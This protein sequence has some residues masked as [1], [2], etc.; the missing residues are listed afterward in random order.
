M[1]SPER[2]P[3]SGVARRGERA[4]RRYGYRSAQRPHL[5]CLRY[6]ICAGILLPRHDLTKIGCAA[7][8][9]TSIGSPAGSVALADQQTAVYPGP[10]PGGWR[11]I[12]SCPLTLFNLKAAPALLT[13]GDSVRFE[14]VSESEFRAL[15]GSYDRI[16]HQSR[17]RRVNS[18]GQWPHWHAAIG[19]ASSGAM[20][21]PAL[22][23]GQH[24]LGHTQDE[25]AI[26]MAYANTEVTPDSS[27]LIAVTGAPVSLWVDGAP[28]ASQKCS[29]SVL[30]NA[31]ALR[32][33]PMESIAIS[34]SRAASP[35]GRFR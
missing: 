14:P 2:C 35:L 31:S 15:G 27:C 13:I 23:S 28:A 26:E 16:A 19:L 22:V 33:A 1:V 7:T 20:D 8:G 10:S 3:R 34:M 21:H 12:G 32:L 18:A 6:R 25:A 9:D 4:Q 29:K 5:F 30:A 11:L 24:L 17:R